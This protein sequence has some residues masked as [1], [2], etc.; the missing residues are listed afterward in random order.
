MNKIDKDELYGHVQE[1]L[2]GKGVELQDGLY[3]RRIRQGCD[4]L[5]K[6]ING[7]REALNRAK[8][9]ADRRLDEV[10]QVIHEKTAPRRPTGSPPPP[11]QPA[12]PKTKTAPARAK[13]PS[14][15]KVAPTK[16]KPRAAQSKKKA[17]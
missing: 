7:S 13:A 6:T 11:P 4:I 5:A 16:S 15:A 12:A 3:T 8:A 17:Q 1:F 2:K 10:R 9:E 14:A